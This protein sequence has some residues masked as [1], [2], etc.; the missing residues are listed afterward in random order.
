MVNRVEEENSEKGLGIGNFVDV[1]YG[2]H[3]ELVGDLSG[4]DGS[5]AE[6]VEPPIVLEPDLGYLIMALGQSQSIASQPSKFSPH[7]HLIIQL[8]TLTH[9]SAG[10]SPTI[11]KL[12]IEFDEDGVVGPNHAKWN[13]RVGIYVRS[14]IPIHYKD[15]RKIDGS[16]KDNVRIN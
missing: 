4:G 2:M 15:W 7:F 12:P 13:T 11:T 14:R 6:D 1:A 10:N 5:Q 3:E 9:I 8:R 16:F